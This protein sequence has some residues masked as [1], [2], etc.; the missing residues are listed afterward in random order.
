MHKLSGYLPLP[1]S[2]VSDGS[3]SLGPADFSIAGRKQVY[4]LDVT[5]VFTHM[6][7]NLVRNMH[8]D[9]NNWQ[10]ILLLT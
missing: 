6:V 2:K 9:G 1:V 4:G 8:L 7:M 10:K 3:N 5:Q